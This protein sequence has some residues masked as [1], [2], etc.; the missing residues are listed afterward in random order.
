MYIFTQGL[1]CTC[2]GL[3]YTC[4]GLV[5]T[6]FL[7]ARNDSEEELFLTKSSFCGS[8][9]ACS[10]QLEGMEQVRLPAGMLRLKR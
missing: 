4:V 3:V 5:C 8:L 1:V 9:E 2:V 6:R 7:A 10:W